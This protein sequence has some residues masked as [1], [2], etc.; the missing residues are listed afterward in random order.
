MAKISHKDVLKIA[1]LSRISLSPE[2]V[3]QYSDE[4]SEILTFVEQLQS[5]DTTNIRP[6]YQVNNL[7]SVMRADEVKAYS[8][9]GIEL[10]KNAPDQA[11]N[12]FKVKKVL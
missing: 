12:H 5:I 7:Q 10:L 2:E 8:A 9:N 1:S 3:T 11:A 4:I 6:T